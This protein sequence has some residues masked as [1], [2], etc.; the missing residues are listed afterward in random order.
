[1]EQFRVAVVMPLAGIR[2][3]D[4][5]QFLAGPYATQIL[6][7]LGADVV[8]VEAPSGDLT[9]SLPP[10]FIGD[11]S[12]YYLANNRNKRSIAVDL[13]TAKGV[14]VVRRLIPQADVVIENFRPGK[15][16]ALGVDRTDL[17]RGNPRLVWCSISGF[18]QDGPRRDQPAYDMVVQ[19]LSGSMSLTGTE[20]GVPVRTGIPIG[21]LAAGLHAVIGI[22]AALR[23]REVSGLGDHIDVAMLDCLVSMLNYQGVYH[24]VSGDVPTRQGRGHDSIP[25]YRAFTARDDVDFVVTANTEEMWRSLC[26]VFGVSALTDDPRF[27]TNAARFVHRDELW[28]LLEEAA[29]ARTAR[30]WVERFEEAGV[31][32]ALV[33]SLKETFADGQVRARQIVRT[34][35]ADEG[36]SVD[37]LDTP[38][39]ME[40]IKERPDRYPPALGQDSSEVLREWVDMESAEL[41]SLIAE[42]VVGRHQSDSR[43]KFHQRTELQR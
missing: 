38:I 27:E 22:V 17:M 42:G 30:D 24:L 18:G 34:L 11:D 5:T 13:K 1:M 14:A 3:L 40:S 33:N 10:H 19:A 35:T 31:P 9:R 37:V 7:D 26:R 6:G 36:H 15:L 29:L 16:A 4:F 21:D 2:I 43:Q 41:E 12:A 32:V 28:P 25:T 8:K 39:R 20:D 23:R